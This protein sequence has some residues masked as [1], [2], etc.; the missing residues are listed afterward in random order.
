MEKV[1]GTWL[2]RHRLKL[3]VRGKPS[4]R[5]E[6]CR[7]SS[8]KTAAVV[9]VRDYDGDGKLEAYA[10]TITCWSQPA[11]GPTT[12]RS[13][14]LWSLHRKPRRALRADFGHDALPTAAG[15]EHV[16]ARFVDVNKD[17]HPD[18]VLTARGE[19]PGQKPK[20]PTKTVYLWRAK[21]D[22]WRR[23]K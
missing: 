8:K 11:I 14:E 16:R 12:F 23:S 13:M 18:V 9:F 20:K 17:G 4:R 19:Y 5:S 21:T 1:D 6:A 2:L 3:H 15:A 22:T 10:R 7:H